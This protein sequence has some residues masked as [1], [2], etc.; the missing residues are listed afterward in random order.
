M[1]R[2]STF[3]VLSSTLAVIALSANGASAATIT[4]HTT[5]PR[6]IVH[7]P[8]PKV[9]VHTPQLKSLGNHGTVVGTKSGS[10]HVLLKD[11]SG[12][13]ANKK[14]DSSAIQSVGN[15]ASGAVVGRA[16]FDVFSL[17]RK[18]DIASPSFFAAATSGA[19]FSFNKIDPAAKASVVFVGQQN[20]KNDNANTALGVSPQGAENLF[21]GIQ[22]GGEPGV[23]LAITLATMF[24]AGP[25][26]N[27]PGGPTGN[28]PITPQTPKIEKLN[29]HRVEK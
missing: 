14:I 23:A 24:A 12:E 18:F 28:N 17:T 15:P 3:C 8:Q 1:T 29:T 6:V 11:G 5:V 16:T 27:N 26:E 20:L 9:N 10:N 4:V 21:N 22:K 2:I 7:V 25:T 13:I 19:S